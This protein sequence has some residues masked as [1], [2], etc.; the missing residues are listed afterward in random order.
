MQEELEEHR[1]RPMALKA[2]LPGLVALRGLD[3]PG[4]TAVGLL[5]KGLGSKRSSPQVLAQE[6]HRPLI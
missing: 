1:P 2:R 4:P 5:Q 6:S 3:F